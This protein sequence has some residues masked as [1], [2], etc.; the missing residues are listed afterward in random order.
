MRLLKTHSHTSNGLAMEPGTREEKQLK[1]SQ[2]LQQGKSHPSKTCRVPEVWRGGGAEKALEPVAY[3]RCGGGGQKRLYGKPTTGRAP[4]RGEPSSIWRGTQARV[5][6]RRTTKPS[7]GPSAWRGRTRGENRGL[8]LAS[9]SRGLVFPQGDTTGPKSRE[10]VFPD[11]TIADPNIQQ[12]ATDGLA[13]SVFAIFRAQLERTLAFFRQRAKKTQGEKPRVRICVV[14]SR[15]LVSPDGDIAGPDSN[16]AFDPSLEYS[17]DKV[18][19]F[20]Q[21]PFHFSP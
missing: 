7:R 17:T 10:L 3:R 18:V 9:C 12:L 14:R 1:E 13:P 4:R 15:S 21:P 19:L 8:G 2:T 11:G 16:T 6:G 5:Q 20:Q